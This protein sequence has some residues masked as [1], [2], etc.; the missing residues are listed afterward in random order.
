MFFGNTNDFQEM[1]RGIPT[2]ASHVI[3]RMDKVPYMDQSGLYAMEE[4]LYRFNKDNITVILV[5]LETQ[6]RVM[7]E[8]ID[9]IPDLIPHE[10]IF[11]DFD[12]VLAYIKE[13]VEDTVK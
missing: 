11:S 13:N 4:A 3:I 6:P 8:S 1:A 12:E 10:H 5:H 2:T 7:M 9:I